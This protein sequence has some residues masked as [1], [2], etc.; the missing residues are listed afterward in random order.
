MIIL[1][2]AN[3][4]RKYSEEILCKWLPEYC[5]KDKESRDKSNN[6]MPLQNILDNALNVF[7]P[8]FGITSNEYNQLRKYLRILLNPLSHAD[9]GVERYKGEINQVIHIIKNLEVLHASLTLDIIISGGEEVQ[10]RQIASNGDLFKG[11]YELNDSLYRL[12]DSVGAIKYSTFS[13]RFTGW[14]KV[15]VIGTITNG[16]LSNK[17]RKANAR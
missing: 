7:W 10:I 6:K 16:V 15:E 11:I 5:W 17:P 1:R 4:L 9:V 2:L 13:G 14:E 12:T 3:Y 8:L